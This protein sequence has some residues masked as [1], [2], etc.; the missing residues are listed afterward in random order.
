MEYIS[1]KEAS[2]KWGISER[3]VRALCESGRIEG[4]SRC[5][6]WVWSIP[7]DTPRPADGRTLRYIKN[8]NLRTGAQDYSSVD[9]IRKSARNAILT[10]YQKASV[11]QEAFAY[12]DI[13]LEREQILEIFRLKNQNI[14][15]ETQIEILNM[16]SALSNLSMDISENSICN[17]NK[18]ILMSVNEKDGGNYKDEISGKETI[19]ILS[20][21]H[22]PWSVL[23][24][25]ARGAFLFAEL[26]RVQ[27]FVKCNIQTAFAVLASELAKAKLPPAI[28]GLDHISELKAALASAKMRG[29]T[30]TL[31]SMILQASGTK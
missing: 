2:Q 31:V 17:L 6:D 21:Y 4:V 3:R 20:Q 7:K 14:P 9:K 28:F 12:A 13:N 25:V 11:I 23:H 30:Q 15:L 22:G 27:P 16:R 26:I 10:D 8:R 5:G 29:N 18:R 19:A 24:P 1:V